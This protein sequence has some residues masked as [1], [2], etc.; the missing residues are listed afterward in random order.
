MLPRRCREGM[1]AWWSVPS[2]SRSE[3]QRQQYSEEKGYRDPEQRLVD[4]LEQS[5]RRVVRIGIPEQH[6]DEE[7]GERRGAPEPR[8]VRRR[9]E[10]QREKKH[11]R[12]NSCGRSTLDEQERHRTAGDHRNDATCHTCE[13]YVADRSHHHQCCGARPADVVEVEDE[14]D[15]G[16][17]RARRS[18]T[19]PVTEAGRP[20]ADR[21]R[22]VRVRVRPWRT[23]RPVPSRRQRVL[24]ARRTRRLCRS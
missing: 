19:Q 17:E 10:R 1:D 16:G 20:G 7:R 2:R 14:P 5:G 8:S 23:T 3:Q 11:C 9:C 12:E 6:D 22:P 15:G 13:L 21:R 24:S 18:E 4:P